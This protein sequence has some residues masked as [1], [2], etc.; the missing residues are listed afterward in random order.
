M[1]NMCVLSKVGRQYACF[2]GSW[3]MQ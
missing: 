3:K 1:K 2:W